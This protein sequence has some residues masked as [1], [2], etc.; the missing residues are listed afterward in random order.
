MKSTELLEL[1]ANAE[2]TDSK[3]SSTEIIK[4]ERI[5]GTPFVAIKEENK[6][7]F[8]TLGRYKVME[9]FEELEELTEYIHSQT[10][11]WEFL[12]NV[13]SVVVHELLQEEK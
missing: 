12:T 1:Q 6:D 9:G 11:E 7:W 5:E 8:I 10:V 13:I 3:N 2:K 4:R